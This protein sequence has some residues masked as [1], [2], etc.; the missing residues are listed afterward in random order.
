M[1]F[2]VAFI[3]LCLHSVHS[4]IWSSNEDGIEK[5]TIK[6]YLMSKMNE[7]NHL[8]VVSF[9]KEQKARMIIQHKMVY[10]WY[11][12]MEEGSCDDVMAK[13]QLGRVVKA[14]AC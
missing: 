2:Y 13:R 1:S 12:G 4:V 3:F 7:K 11:W 14:I 8:V 10:F 9:Y 5:V 6:R